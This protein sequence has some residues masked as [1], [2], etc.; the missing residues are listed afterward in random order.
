M[1]PRKKPTSEKQRAH[2]EK[3]RAAGRESGLMGGRPSSYKVEYAKIARVMCA[4]GATDAELAD[5]FGVIRCTIGRWQSRHK[6]FAAAL[7]VAKGEY[8]DRVERALAQ[9]AIGYSYDT[10]KVFMVGA[11]PV[12]VPYRE[13]IPPDPFAAFRWL[14]CRRKGEW[15]DRRELTAADGD[16]LMPIINLLTEL[17]GGTTSLVETASAVYD[18]T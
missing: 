9:R 3:A 5:A 1:P 2:L 11:Q 10:E 12:Y 16:P 4:N 14:S 8:D 17:N 18:N 13:H 15:R 6:E 7:K